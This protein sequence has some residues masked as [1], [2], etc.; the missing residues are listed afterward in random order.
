MFD[1]TKYDESITDEEVEI[2]DN[3]FD[4]LL[5]DK[6]DVDTKAAPVSE[7][8]ISYLNYG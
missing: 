2:I 8:A 3:F 5:M 6:L 1:R 4:S 7:V